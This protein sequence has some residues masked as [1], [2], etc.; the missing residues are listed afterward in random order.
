MFSLSNFLGVIGR[1][2]MDVRG[3]KRQKS[4]ISQQ[5]FIIIF[6]HLKDLDNTLEN[7]GNSMQTDQI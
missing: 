7:I 5:N 3:L 6:F 4:R 2:D 1:M